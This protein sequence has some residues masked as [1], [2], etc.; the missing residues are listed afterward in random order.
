MA[1]ATEKLVGELVEEAQDDVDKQYQMRPKPLKKSAVRVFENLFEI[2]LSAVIVLGLLWVAFYVKPG[3]VVD[4]I[5]PSPFGRREN[6]LGVVAPNPDGSVL[7]ATG[8]RGRIIRSDDGGATWRIQA[9]PVATEHLQDIAVWSQERA[10]VVG[11]QGVVLTTD[12]GGQTWR[13]VEIQTREFGEQLLRAY[14]QPDGG[15]AWIVGT[16]GSVFVSDDQGA[17]WRM[18]HEEEDLAWNGITVTPDGVVWVVGEFGRMSRSRDGGV[19]WEQIDSGAEQSLMA[20]VFADANTGVA[21]G[22]AGTLLVTTDGGDEWEQVETGIETHL[23]DVAW[24]GMR[25]YT[26]GEAGV[27]LTAS[28]NPSGW[29]IGTLGAENSLW[30]MKAVPVAGKLIASG[31]NIGVS[32]DGAWHPFENRDPRPPAAARDR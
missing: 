31:A 9:T 5:E 22:L 30:Y 3:A 32:V 24:D 17:T 12:D 7:W 14:V 20:V 6:Y 16:M 27:L 19:T 13:R 11:D 15:R 25:F 1:V 29:N 2:A 10:L 23:F 4:D 18:T 8:R 28:G 21:V 26:V